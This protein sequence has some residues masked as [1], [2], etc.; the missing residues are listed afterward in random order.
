VK[1]LDCDTI[2]PDEWTLGKYANAFRV[3]K[4]DVED[5]CILEF[6]VY[7]ARE[8]QASV[9]TRVKISKSFLPTIRERL[10]EI[11]FDLGKLEET[12]GFSSW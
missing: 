8:K 12:N 5:Y 11:L 3:Q 2:L 6:L 1:R 9:V 4:S 10:D 7:S